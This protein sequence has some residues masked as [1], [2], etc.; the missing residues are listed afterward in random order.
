MRGAAVVMQVVVAGGWLCCAPS[1]CQ[2]LSAWG[3]TKYVLFPAGGRCRGVMC[4]AAAL[5]G[6]AGEAYARKGGCN[7]LPQ[8]GRGLQVDEDVWVL[9]AVMSKPQGSIS[10]SCTPAHLCTTDELGHCVL[11]F[12]QA[13]MKIRHPEAA[14][15]SQMIHV[16]LLTLRHAGTLQ[17]VGH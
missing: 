13:C 4:L 7:D 9:A 11:I 12:L 6:P 2:A 16:T 1:G 8:G 10:S 14:T 3:L 5:P 15:S 17:H